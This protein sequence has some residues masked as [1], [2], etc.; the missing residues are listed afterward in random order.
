MFF[1]ALRN[2]FILLTILFCCYSNVKTQP[3]AGEV[4]LSIKHTIVKRHAAP[5][6]KP[7]PQ[8]KGGDT[9]SG[10]LSESHEGLE[11]YHEVKADASAL[12]FTAIALTLA[13]V[14]GIVGIYCYW[15][16]TLFMC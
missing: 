6:P 11:V 10:R 12:V 4:Q 9:N 3:I 1:F 8:P 13:L 5:D 7:K 14:G 15:Q 2:L 16:E